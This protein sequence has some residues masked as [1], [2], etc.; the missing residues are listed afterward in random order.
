MQLPTIAPMDEALRV[1]LRTRVD[2]LAKPPGSLGQIEDL[3]VRT[4]LIQGKLAP[5]VGAAA[6]FVFAGDHGLTTEGV[7]AYPSE[8]TAIMVETFL[9]GRASANAFAHAVDAAVRVVDAGI[10]L[11]PKPDSALIDANVRR[12]T[13]NAA[14][15]PAMTTT[16]VEAA[17]NHG[18]RLAQTAADEGFDILIPGEMGIGNTA[19]AAL[20]MH[21]LASIPLAQCVGR[22]AGHDDAGLARKLAAL[23]RAAA[24]TPVTDP[25]GVLVEF[26]G[27]EIAMMA[28]FIL[29]AAAAR[30]IVI[31]DGF[32][33]SCAALAAIRMAP[34]AMN[35][36][37]F[38]H[39]SAESGHRLLLQALG[40]EPLLDLQMRLGEG[41]GALLTV[42]F[43]RAA[44]RLLSDVALLTEV[45]KT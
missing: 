8:V 21:R 45:V 38:A 1:A 35:Y 15:E 34:D 36:C 42:P 33:S 14:R 7:S 41:T 19:S 28:G 6:V 20:I 30:R 44:A 13:G 24:R 12:G 32:I 29:G 43:V 16:E 10:K 26:G 27:C 31:V 11:I 2:S 40:A 25:S 17:L 22:G 5:S 9:A 18:V 37:I 4:G 3:A 39:R 23:E